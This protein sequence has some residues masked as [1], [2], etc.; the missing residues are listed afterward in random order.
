MEDETILSGEETA[1]NPVSPAVDNEEPVEEQVQEQVAPSYLDASEF[2][3][4]WAEREQALEA[5]FQAQ[6][7]EQAR[8]AQAKADSARDRA[9]QKQKDLLEKYVPIL[10]KAGVEITPE[11][12]QAASNAIREEEFWNQPANVQAPQ[13]QLPTS[14]S[15]NPVT[16]SV[17]QEYLKSQ[18]LKPDALDLSKYYRNPDGSPVYDDDPVKGQQFYA[19]VQQEIKRVQEQARQ[20]ELLRKQQDAQKVAAVKNNIGGTATPPAASGNASSAQTLEQEL[21]KLLKTATGDQLEKQRIRT[22]INEIE[23]ELTNLGRW[24]SQAKGGGQ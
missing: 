4:R 23:R 21:Q 7:Q 1:E 18:G 24:G 13:V 11:N 9:V 20:Q 16:A 3:R 8:R 2:D 10:Q 5:K 15:R 6:L 19:E 22:R 17:L 12:L 14:V